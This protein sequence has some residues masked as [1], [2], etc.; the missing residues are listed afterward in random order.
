MTDWI[1][2]NNNEKVLHDGELKSTGLKHN[3]VKIQTICPSQT[4]PN[5]YLQRYAFAFSCWHLNP[6]KCESELVWGHLKEPRK[7]ANILKGTTKR[8]YRF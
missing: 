5:T 2:K 8:Q 1:L 4:D 6:E 3:R 7:E